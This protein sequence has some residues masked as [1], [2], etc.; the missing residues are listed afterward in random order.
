MY[1]APA[2]GGSSSRSHSRASSRRL[3][4]APRPGPR[5]PVPR[6]RVL[7]STAARRR[8][9]G[10]GSVGSARAAWRSRSAGAAGG[11]LGP[12]GP[13]ITAR[14]PRPCSPP[15]YL[16]GSLKGGGGMQGEEPRPHR[17]TWA[18]EAPWLSGLFSG[19]H[20]LLCLGA[21]LLPCLRPLFLYPQGEELPGAGMGYR[22]AR[23]VGYRQARYRQITL[24]GQHRPR[25]QSRRADG[26]GPSAPPR[27]LCLP[28][29]LMAVPYPHLRVLSRVQ[30]FETPCTIAHQAPPSMGI[31]QARIL[32]WVAMPSSR[33]P[34]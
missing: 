22:Q 7:T 8:G 4:A 1:Q 13:A 3:A 6:A 5:T 18:P 20:L 14:R 33:E 10:S 29:P 32:E 31:L 21:P 26:W 15:R 17:R 9:P 23:K 12:A 27:P 16:P 19:N 30:L 2:G 25:W 24:G 28:P 34:S 11:E